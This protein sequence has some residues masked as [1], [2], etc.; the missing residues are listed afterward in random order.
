MVSFLSTGL[1]T[2][3]T[4]FSKW[5]I[6]F[7]DERVVPFDDD[8]STFGIY[9]KQL[10][11]KVNLTEEQFVKIKQGVSGIIN[12]RR[13]NKTKGTLTSICFLHVNI[14]AEEAAIDYLRQMSLYFPPESVPRF[15][16]LLLGMGP[17][18]HTCSLFPGHKLVEERSRWVAPISDS[19]KPPSAR[20][21]LTFPVINN[22]KSCVFATAGE[23]K[24]DMV[25]VDVN[26]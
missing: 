11:G 23:G 18:G 2:I 22:A 25:K 14:A 7:C 15:D 8:D 20:I 9:K 1:L 21:T 3:N 10:V 4:D 26:F 6:F 24:A 12:N 17:D 16:M 13:S 19:P 5:R